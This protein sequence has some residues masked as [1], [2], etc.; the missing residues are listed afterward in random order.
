MKE[1]IMRLPMKTK[2]RIYCRNCGYAFKLNN[3]GLCT[4]CEPLVR[5]I[6]YD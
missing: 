6:N 5:F 3:N 1:I 4:K 2:P